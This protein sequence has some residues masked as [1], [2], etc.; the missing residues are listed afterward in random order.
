MLI[1]SA[2]NE[3]MGVL[4]RFIGG[5]CTA[6]V[7][8]SAFS[9]YARQIPLGGIQNIYAE[10]QATEGGALYTALPTYLTPGNS[11]SALPDDSKAPGN[12]AL[13]I[14]NKVT[15]IDCTRSK[16]ERITASLDGVWLT[17]LYEGA[18]FHAYDGDAVLADKPA[19]V[20]GI[21]DEKDISAAGLEPE[22][23]CAVY[24]RAFVIDGM[25]DEDIA[26]LEL[27]GARYSRRVFVNGE[28][29]GSYNYDYSA[30][31]FDVTRFLRDG[32]NEI[33]IL[34]GGISESDIP[35]AGAN[36]G[37][38]DSVNLIITGGAFIGNIKSAPSVEDGTVLI[39][40]EIENFTSEELTETVNFTVYELGIVEDGVSSVH[41]G[42]GFCRPM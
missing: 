22:T 8:L 28:F 17:G 9:A 26:V 13:P 34:L 20:P 42:C 35:A 11:G 21:I 30:S 39:T 23:L 4:K 1:F 31:R 3:K 16:N 36:P 32:E 29:A 15:E 18:F 7:A 25:S 27:L 38:T 5:V 40:A 6:A 41:T 37:I 33:V 24:K 14:E 2:K 10:T 19:P 12:T